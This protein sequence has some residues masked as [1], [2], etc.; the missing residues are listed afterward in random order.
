MSGHDAMHPIADVWGRLKNFDFCAEEAPVI[1]WPYMLWIKPST[2]EMKVRNM[3]DTAWQDVGVPQAGLD[4]PDG[5][6]LGIA[7]DAARI[8]FHAADCVAVMGAN[9]GVGTLTPALALDV[10]GRGQL[11]QDGAQGYLG[12]RAY[13]NAANSVNFAMQGARGSRAVPAVSQDG[14][15]VGQFIAYGYSV[16]AGGFLNCAGIQF[17]I[18]G[19]PD[20][21]ADPTDMPGKIVFST[22]PDGSATLVNQ[23]MISQDGGLALVDGIAAPAAEAGWMKFYVDNAD[24][25]LK[26]KFGNG[27]VKT[28]VTDT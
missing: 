14:D 3:A 1:T 17:E 13:R 15:R 2:R 16:A 12:L 24:G 28:I 8:V 7:S 25:D 23:A 18:D 9:F 19:T 20:S 27:T 21:G 10:A 5:W 11:I 6:W 26:V 22:C 4:V